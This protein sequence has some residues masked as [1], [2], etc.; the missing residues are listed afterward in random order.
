MLFSVYSIYGAD[1]ENE[2]GEC[3]GSSETVESAKTDAQRFDDVAYAFRRIKRER[4]LMP[5]FVPVTLS[6]PDACRIRYGKIGTYDEVRDFVNDYAFSDAADGY[7]CTAEPI[8]TYYSHY[9]FRR[10]LPK[11][12]KDWLDKR[13]EEK[14]RRHFGVANLAE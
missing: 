14:I 8:I 3:L 5:W 2:R 13:E 7:P 1:K 10:Q 9:W 6:G 11:R 12:L 4:Y